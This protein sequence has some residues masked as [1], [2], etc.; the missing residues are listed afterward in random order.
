[1][2]LQLILRKQM[3]RLHFEDLFERQ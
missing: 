3:A 1:V 2:V